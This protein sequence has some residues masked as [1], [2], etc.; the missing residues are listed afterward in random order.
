MKA[1][2]LIVQFIVL[3]PDALETYKQQVKPILKAHSGSPVTAGKFESL[4]GNSKYTHISIFRFPKKESLINWFNSKEYQS[5]S[6]IRDEAI[7]SSF[8]VIEE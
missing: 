4:L 7:D 1:A 2:L 3:N 6:K 8:I 5:L